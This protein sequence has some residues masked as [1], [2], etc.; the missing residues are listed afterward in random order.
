M[1]PTPP[2]GSPARRARLSPPRSSPAEW[3]SEPIVRSRRAIRPRRAPS[4]PRAR[5][6]AQRPGTQGPRRST[7]KGGGIDAHIR[8]ST[9]AAMR[10]C[11]SWRAS[12]LRMHAAEQR[13]PVCLPPQIATPDASW[14]PFWCAIGTRG[15]EVYR[16][17][18]ASPETMF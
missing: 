13:E 1:S 12:G 9:T 15:N 16:Y 8:S 10:A 14:D 17:I 2:S 5:R 4:A 11:E 3:R 18:S 7:K 6:R